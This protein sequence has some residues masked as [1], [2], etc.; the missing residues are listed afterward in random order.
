[1]AKGNNKLAKKPVAEES[2]DWLITYADAITLLM[3]FFVL[4]NSVS[5]IELP[6]IEKLQ[7]G[8]SEGLF[9]EQA[10]QPITLLEIDIEDILFSYNAESFSEVGFDEDGIVIE[11]QSQAFFE[12]AS[13]N[14][15]REGAQMLQQ[16]A[17]TLLSPRYEAYTIDIEGHTDN[18]PIST[19]LFPSNWELSATRATNVVR[20]LI[21]Q[22]VLP[23]RMKAIGFSDTQPKYPNQ[24]KAGNPIPENQAQNRRLTLRVHPRRF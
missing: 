13:A 12:P 10:I 23:A 1:V 16:I 22:G 17:Q 5:K 20:F 24:D 3:A 15:K 6:M 8:I 18:T 21:D 19:P 7:A 4:L 2:E 9:Q 14:I 11:F